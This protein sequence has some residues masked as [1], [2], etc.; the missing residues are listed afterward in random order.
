MGRENN[1]S[2][3]EI[4]QWLL[5]TP[6]PEQKQNLKDLF[7]ERILELKTSHTSALDILKI[8]HRTLNGILNGTQKTVDMTNLL[9]L[10]DFLQRPPEDI[11]KLYLEELKTNFQKEQFLPSK[12]IDFIRDNFDLAALKKANF[13]KSISD[14]DEIENRIAN[15][16]GLISIRNYKRP[17]VDVAFSKGLIKPK[18][19]LTRSFWI[20]TASDIFEGLDNS[21]DYNRQT[22]IDYFPQI[23]WHSTNVELGLI[24]IIRDLFKMGITIIYLSP[25]PSLNL[26]G[27]TFAVNN[28]PC[29]VLTDY[30]GFYSTLWFAL[31]HELFHVVFDW[32]EIKIN[33]YHISEE[34]PEQL[35]VLK[36]EEE[37]N[38]F[39]R[40]YLF[41]KE[42]TDKIRPYLNDFKYVE[43]FAKTNQVHP[44]LIYAFNA[45]DT[46]NKNRMAWAIA[47]MHNPKLKSLIGPLENPWD[48]PKP[49]SE[50]VKS[51][52]YKFYN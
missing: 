47:R 49:I 21:N 22:I 9:K 46:G 40:D 36:K 38:N 18:N 19:E 39:S 15:F 16:F 1:E 27:A 20:K 45:F 42:K 10:A 12:N 32:D 33:R 48:S 28:K 34:D 43:E 31:I 7:N 29:I 2:Y 5:K 24:N 11:I 25:L 41:S 30:K 8:Q 4:M 23:R 17:P 50:F 51:I 44:S 37:A 6:P 26:R 52:K 14:Y 13:I 3:D 35:S